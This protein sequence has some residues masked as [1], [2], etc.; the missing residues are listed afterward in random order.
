VASRSPRPG[1][2]TRGIRIPNWGPKTSLFQWR[3]PAFW[4][5]ALLLLIT[6]LLSLSQQASLLLASPGGFL[7]SW[8]LLL[9]YL[10]PMFFLIYWFVDSYDREPLSLVFGALIWGAISATSLAAIANT[11][12]STV[13]ARIG[14]PDF[15][16]VWSAALTA[17]VVEEGL[18]ATGVV[19]IYLIAPREVNDIMDGFVY[20]AMVGLG[21]TVVEDVYYFV[22]AFGGT[23]AGVIQGF[24]VRVVLSGLYGHVVYTGLTGIGIAYFVT[25]KGEA[26]LGKRW[27]VMIGLFL[28]AMTAHFLWNLP[29]FN[30]LPPDDAPGLVKLIM[31]PVG[32]AVKGLPFLAFLALI[33]RLAHRRE[34]YWL[35]KS[36][37]GELGG[38]G[39]LPGELE[40][41]V[42]SRARR[43]A[44]GELRARSGGQAADLLKRIQREQI[45]LAMMRT[46]APS[47]DHPDLVRQRALLHNLRQN[48]SWTTG[49]GRPMVPQQQFGGPPPPPGFR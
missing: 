30:L 1:P 41:L 29:L 42:D 13:I 18:K 22:G 40:V 34:V 23:P 2:V 47:P 26:S 7:L 20:G 8:V 12:W 38:P 46:R 24:I 45:K 21:F 4:G 6:G 5:F 31:I 39:L 25:R 19:L 10:V 37:E 3:N 33:L 49:G 15:A 36:L 32:L 35:R 27:L 9:F 28:T 16:T 11:D 43:R 44:R 17:P 14:G 48:L